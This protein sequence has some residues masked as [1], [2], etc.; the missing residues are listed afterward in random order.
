MTQ[1]Q[2]HSTYT[3]ANR[4][5]W[6]D[7]DFAILLVQPIVDIIANETTIRWWHP[8]RYTSYIN[9]QYS[10]VGD[11]IAIFTMHRDV[12]AARVMTE[13]RMS[14]VIYQDYTLYR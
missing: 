7:V 9:A 13:I 3:P 8:N 14:H 2:Q 12:G 5:Y 6:N 4:T 11:S 1:T 10:Y